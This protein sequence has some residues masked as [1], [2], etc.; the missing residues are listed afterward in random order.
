MK[1]NFARNRPHCLALVITRLMITVKGLLWPTTAKPTYLIQVRSRH[2]QTPDC[3]LV[4]RK[5]VRNISE[6]GTESGQLNILYVELIL[7]TNH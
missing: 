3:L 6:L 4:L 2:L 1:I 5:L 7:R